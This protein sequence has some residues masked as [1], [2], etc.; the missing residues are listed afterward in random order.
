MMKT[1]RAVE[2]IGVVGIG[3]RFPGGVIDPESLW[4]ILSKGVDAVRE[5][6][7]DRLD[8]KVFHSPGGQ[9][10]GTF[11][12]RWG[13]F[14][15]QVDRFAPEFFGISAREACGM[16]PQQRLLLEVSWEAFE[17][18]GIPP[19]NIAGSDAGVFIGMS[20][21][22]FSDIQFGDR[23]L[24]LIDN[25]TA[26]GGAM[27]IAANRISYFF[28][29]HGPSA[30]VDTAC[31]SSL[32]AIHMACR[33]LL[34]G[35]CSMAL[36]GGVNLLLTPGPFI[37]FSKASML[38]PDGR[39]K[40]FDAR[41]NGYV[42]AEGAGLLVL[43]PLARALADGDRVYAVVLGTAMN[44]DG[45]SN[46]LTVPNG[47]AQAALTRL[48]ID[49]AG[50]APRDIGYV[51]AHGTGTPVGDP[52]EAAAL[53]A[54]LSEGRPEGDTCLVGSVKTNLGHL[55]AA[56]GIAG[57]IKAILSVERRTILPSLH[58]ISGNPAIPFEKLKLRVPTKLEPWPDRRAV[59]CVNSFGFGGTNAH[60]VVAELPREHEA[61]PSPGMEL[62]LLPLSARRPDDLQA[63]ISSFV[64][65]LADPS[66]DGEF[67]DI[68]YAAGAR[69]SHHEHR[70]AVLGRSPSDMLNGL[71]ALTGG[72]PADGVFTGEAIRSRAPRIAFVCSGMG[73]QWWGMGRQ[74]LASCPVFRDAIQRIDS[75]LQ[76]LTSWSLLDEMNAGV[77]ASRMEET[78]VAQPAN[79]ALQVGLAA[80]WRSWGVEPAAIAGHSAGE[81]AAAYLAG[82][83]SLEEAVR[84]VFHR[85]RLQQFT[86]GEGRMI[87]VGLSPEDVEKH[88][89]RLRVEIA[90]VN[91]TTD[92]TL[93]VETGSIDEVVS[94]CESA[95]IFYRV[96]RGQV[97]Y[98]GR[99]MDRLRSDLSA[100]VA[101][102]RLDTV[103]TLMI[104]SVTG[105]AV[106]GPELNADY[107]W[108][109][110]R[111]TV[112]FATAIDTLA[113]A[114]IDT[115]IE[116]A[117]HPVLGG[118]IA[119]RLDNGKARPLVLHSLKRGGDECESMLSNLAALYTAGQRIDWDGLHGGRRR[120]V[121]LPAYPWQRE[122]HWRESSLSRRERIDSFTHPLLG[123]AL[124]T[125]KPS[126][127]SLVDL[128]RLPY[129]AD[130]RVEG[131]I[132]YPAAAYVEMALACA[133]R[134]IASADTGASITV[135]SVEIH[136]ALFINADERV[137]IQTTCDVDDARFEIHAQPGVDQP[138]SLKA[139]GRILQ[140]ATPSLR[141]GFAAPSSRCSQEVSTTDCYAL[142]R[143]L[144]LEYGP[145][146]QGV[147]SLWRGQR[148][149][150][151]TVRVPEAAGASAEEYE[152]HP[153]ILDAAFQ[154]LIGASEG[155]VAL[156]LP[157][158]IDRLCLYRRGSTRMDVHAAVRVQTARLLIGDI[159]LYDDLGVA[160][161]LKGFRCQGLR[162]AAEFAAAELARTSLYRVEWRQASVQ[163]VSASAA[164][165]F[166]RPEEIATRVNPASVLDIK[167][168]RIFEA[169]Q[170]AL[171]ARAS[172]HIACGLEELGI[173]N[174]TAPFTA[175]ELASQVGVPHRHRHL[176]RRLL[177]IMEQD[178]VV[179]R[180]DSSRWRLPD[181]FAPQ[182]SPA[183]ADGDAD[184]GSA[185]LILVNRCGAALARV[186]KG[187]LDALELLFPGGSVEESARIYE[188]SSSFHTYNVLVRRA[189]A[190][191]I[192][193]IPSDH[194]LRVIE[195]GA[196]TGG[197]SAGAVVELQQACAQY[198]VT[199]ASTMFASHLSR[200]FEK[201]SFV[202]F[203]TL[204]IERDPVDQGFEANAFDIV[205][206]AD[207]LHATRDL[208]QTLRHIQTL[209]APGGILIALEVTRPPRWVDLVFG[210]TEGWFRFQD[211]ELR[212]ESALLTPEAW[213]ALLEQA[214][215]TSPQVL[216]HAHLETPPPQT[217]LIARQDI[218]LDK[219]SSKPRAQEKWLI[220]KGRD[221]ED[222]GSLLAK[223]LSDAGAAVRAIEAGTGAESVTSVLE[224]L[225][226]E[227]GKRSGV[228]YFG[229]LDATE[230]SMDPPVTNLVSVAQ[231][232][233]NTPPL[234]PLELWIVTRG[235][236][237][238][239]TRSPA[240][241]PIVGVGRVV[242]NE[243]PDIFTRLVDLDANS[244]GDPLRIVEQVLWELGHPGDEEEVA[245]RNERR[246]VSRIARIET[247][248]ESRLLSDGTAARLVVDSP[249]MLDGLRLRAMEPPAPG[250]GE[251]AI[252]IR[253]AGLNFRDVMLSMGLL[254]N[255]VQE[256][257]YFGEALGMECS[258]TVVATGLGVEAWRVGEDVVAQ[259]KACLA[260]HMVTRSDLVSRKPPHMTF[261]EAASIPVAF[262]TAHYA[263]THL[264]RLRRGDRILIHAAAGGV[265]LAAVHLAQRAG[266]EIYATAGTE[267]KRRYLRSIG[268]SHV[269]NSRD[270]SFVDEVMKLTNNEGI[271]VVLNSL[272]GEAIPKSLSVL[273]SQG[274]FLEIGKVDIAAD[275]RLAMGVFAN[276]LSFFAIDIDRILHLRPTYAAELFHEVMDY[277]TEHRI[278]AMP[279]TVAP[280]SEAQNAFRDMA[281]GKH[282]GK[283]VLS[284]EDPLA[285]VTGRTATPAVRADATYLITGGLGGFG[286]EVARWLVTQGARNLVLVGRHGAS[287]PEARKAVEAFVEAGVTIRVES[288]DVSSA[289]SVRT[290][291]EGIGSM[292]PLRG[293]LHA[294]MVLDDG[295]LTQLDADRIRRVLAPKAAGAW[296]LHNQTLGLSLDFFV[297]FSSVAATYGNP[298]QANYVAANL[299]LD[300]LAHYRRSLGLP[301][302]SIAW[303]AL[304][305]VGY[306]ARHEDISQFLERHGLQPFQPEE[307]LALL[308]Q[309]I[310]CGEACV[311]AARMDW[312]RWGKAYPASSNSPRFSQ[313]MV[314]ASS[315]A[316]AGGDGESVHEKLIRIPVE[317]RA[318]FLTDYVADRVSRVLRTS[319]AKLNFEVP[320]TDQGLDSLMAVEL[321]H[322]LEV[323]LD[324]P[325]PVTTLLQGPSIRTLA[326]RLLDQLRAGE[327]VTSG[328]ATAAQAVSASSYS[329]LVPLRAS[330]TRRPIFFVHPS[331]GEVSCYSEL[332]S[333]LGENQPFHAFEAPGLGG[334]GSPIN[335]VEALAVKYVVALRTVQPQG[336]YLI[337]GYSMGGA[338]AFEMV[339]QLKRQGQQTALFALIDSPSPWPGHQPPDAA[340]LAAWFVGEMGGGTV[341]R[342]D[343]AVADEERRLDAVIDRI[344]SHSA[345]Q[346]SREVA[347]RLLAVFTAN[348]QALVGY[349]PERYDGPVI[350]FG[351][352]EAPAEYFRGHPAVGLESFGWNRWLSGSLDVHSVAAN[353]HSILTGTHAKE[354]AILL[355]AA[356][357]KN[358]AA[359]AA[360]G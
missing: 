180:V 351:S 91:G 161:E 149:V 319:A 268:V 120:F 150:V 328:E 343:F 296:N 256:L 248:G 17:D 176:L 190:A 309:L 163:K 154:A 227:P 107:W 63:V 143:R 133:R 275:S 204:D 192:R 350:Y 127:E 102:L 33:A 304:G 146:F 345:R 301:A 126:W 245:I 213:L 22:D 293:V 188:D 241:F 269:M 231:G 290:L 73:P 50:I 352:S 230:D 300:A 76:P 78:H 335:N 43:K 214:G 257:S 291:M 243:L 139:R 123:E 160:A 187:E 96:L 130:H 298:G 29:L 283:I 110:V 266:A 303:G 327:T 106:E 156:Y 45:R 59:A 286:L 236:Q 197:T 253:A 353:H 128:H 178:G 272:S 11:V 170:S 326:E 195:V 129:L 193:D 252:R 27:S 271:D 157:V 92:L 311:V 312:A 297:M 89:G 151:A 284:M 207:V 196:G 167:G 222:I 118:A 168:Q 166:P 87:A 263:L 116:L 249:G 34:A 201:Q 216:T 121:R 357:E 61:I 93:S 101:N 280:V 234:T 260:T 215:F 194:P 108:R 125:A 287:R 115:F 244:K 202:E 140:G 109:N 84:V 24:E 277:F 225:L 28:D 98:H 172:A 348:I 342:D 198:V 82:A 3:C 338:I 285:E 104:S 145:A 119:A 103:R 83:L 321:N 347:R 68:A 44:Q 184:K 72:E 75:L 16:D 131:A 276:N 279:I 220:V 137:V 9:T 134:A 270:L 189:L 354:I 46:G 320:L 173:G 132:V 111:D 86:A 233:A 49:R 205:I 60:A 199:D 38:S 37:G 323:D 85:S 155:A 14:L 66:A 23:N 74:L 281:Q 153:S 254:T 238:I 273:R 294:A 212:P 64:E 21:H 306:L 181:S 218:P 152:L 40:A 171:D 10:P 292:P 55:E 308:G 159:T 182:P 148:E 219:A 79:F 340:Q 247:Q 35:E 47:E 258:G 317:Q 344:G 65:R 114:G 332:C 209:L 223:S 77:D 52:I 12:T 358:S 136:K 58:F 211:A 117:P 112:Q 229:A 8:L 239:E 67:Q 210:L 228:I 235:A 289:D 174:V 25:H 124:S 305:G 30:A 325:I 113:A 315:S 81:V 7:P 70:A 336:P 177:S 322:R 226:A 221:R 333:Y 318:Q 314:P 265:G 164:K 282:M 36:A 359:E 250:P 360:H 183:P 88:L 158:R 267:E 48:A 200:K 307:A 26:T 355:E 329:G 32:A 39:C 169:V 316:A 324:I 4:T 313:L 69:R 135:E 57:I 2:P 341:S 232:I 288:L 6:P 165:F 94:C 346:V 278:P 302:L 349:S 185:E 330:G 179:A 147:E 42:R 31:S 186:L 1:P 144:G 339:H 122:S 97:P 56:S 62:Q 274:R 18:A 138:W 13:G 259:G 95:G 80:L 191:V 19:E 224:D 251:V 175:D 90:A 242:R 261:E 206:A 208:R 71:I 51:E 142:L 203:R 255:A 41:A 162:S 334:E 264:A 54:V 299:Y 337:G 99:P 262:V 105:N 5:I 295:Y 356:V 15:D 310:G 53:G 100:S 237:T 20:T 217:V 141:G 240:Q 331:S 246:M